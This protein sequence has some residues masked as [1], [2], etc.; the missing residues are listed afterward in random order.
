MF[1]ALLPL[2]DVLIVTEAAHP[3]AIDAAE[4]ETLAQQRGYTGSIE[5]VHGVA[6]AMARAVERVGSQGLVC[7]TGSLFVVGEARDA[8]GLPVGHLRTAAQPTASR[9]SSL[10]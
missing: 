4:L 9:L 1:D 8:F 10:D 2:A 5:R 6:A 7:T 3:R